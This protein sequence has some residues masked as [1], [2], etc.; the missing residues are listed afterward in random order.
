MHQWGN[1]CLQSWKSY[2]VRR[3]ILKMFLKRPNQKIYL[4]NAKIDKS[5]SAKIYVAER[6][7]LGDKHKNG[8]RRSTLLRMGKE[9]EL[10]V[11]GVFRFYY[12][13]DIQIFDGGQLE[14][15][16]GFCNSDTKIR[17]KNKISIGHGVAIAHD[18]LIMDCDGHSV[19]G[20]EDLGKPIKIGDHVWIGSKAIILKGVTIGENSIIAAG[21]VVTKAIPSNVIA[22][23]NPARIIKQNSTWR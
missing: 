20:V 10:C 4:N 23:G 22:A 3:D 1:Y 18:V 12:G 6:L 17:C 21:S 2:Q 9:S 15:G 8:Y 16:S 5:N 14:L 11:E 13:C 7:V 19:N